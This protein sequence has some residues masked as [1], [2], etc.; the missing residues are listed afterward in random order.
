MDLKIALG[1]SVIWVIVG[2]SGFQWF[3]G[4]CNLGQKIPKLARTN[5]RQTQS[6]VLLTTMIHKHGKNTPS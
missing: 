5:P 1:N 2:N 4:M 3:L 6:L